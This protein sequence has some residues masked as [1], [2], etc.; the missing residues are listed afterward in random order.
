MQ[1]IECIH[2]KKRY[3]ATGKMRVAMGRKRVRCS[4]CGKSFPIIV[5]E[6]RP[7]GQGATEPHRSDGGKEEK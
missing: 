5:Y 3:P 2:C 7:A 6:S 4:N 1:Y